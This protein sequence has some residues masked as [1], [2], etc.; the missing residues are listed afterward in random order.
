MTDRKLSRYSLANVLS[1]SSGTVT[2]DLG[3]FLRSKQGELALKNAERIV[4]RPAKSETES[5]SA[6]PRNAAKQA[7]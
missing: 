4:I 3:A 2:S 1:N 6:A 7:G 5:T